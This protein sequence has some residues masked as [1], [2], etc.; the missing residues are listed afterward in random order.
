MTYRVVLV[1]GATTVVEVEDANSPE[2]ARQK[3][4]EEAN[5]S[6]CHQCEQDVSIGDEWRPIQVSDASGEVLWHDPT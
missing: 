2:S 4:C 3:A 5:V 6:L 1:S